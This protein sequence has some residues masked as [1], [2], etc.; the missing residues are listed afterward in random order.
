MGQVQ[1]G[2][3]FEGGVS[4]L[5]LGL[6]ENFHLPWAIFNIQVIDSAMSGEVGMCEFL[7]SQYS[8]NSS[9]M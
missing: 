5:P 2:R 4:L 6:R 8:Q 3:G 9:H 1:R 7:R